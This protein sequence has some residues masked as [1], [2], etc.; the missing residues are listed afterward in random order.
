MLFSSS[1]EFELTKGLSIFD[2]VVE[3]LDRRVPNFLGPLPNINWLPLKVSES[4]DAPL[5]IKTFDGRSFYFLHSFAASSE[6]AN[7]CGT[8]EYNGVQ[9]SAIASRGNIIGVQFHPEKSGETGL[10]FL[11]AF[12]WRRYSLSTFY[13]LPEEVV[14]CSR[15]VISN[16]RPSSTV[17]FKSNVKEKTTITFREDGICDACHCKIS[18]ITKLTGMQERKTSADC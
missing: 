12:L 6:S 11:K 14:F 2:G 17:E 9:F 1:E 5:W 15:C 4:Q 7:S 10:M 13:G 8:A 3:R 16:Q 18:K